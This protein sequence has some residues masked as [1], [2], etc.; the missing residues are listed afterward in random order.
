RSSGAAHA[1]GVDLT[2]EMLARA[3]RQPVAAA[4][5]RALPFADG[6][7]D[8]VWCRL[9][10]GHVADL[11]TAYAELGRV[12]RVGGAVV[13][14]DMSAEAIAAGH[15][16]TFRENDGTVREVEHFVH[17]AEAQCAAAGG[18]GLE[19]CEQRD[20]VV[21]ES[22]RAFYVDAGRPAMY[23]EQRGLPL[24]IA[25]SFSRRP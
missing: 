9:V 6:S 17:S 8:V 22:L 25:F 12:C 23:D 21:G 11:G 24:V 13:V 18:A 3:G 10:I 5:V 7:F 19:L 20:G 4:D 14:T 16:R 2:L 1:V 15:R